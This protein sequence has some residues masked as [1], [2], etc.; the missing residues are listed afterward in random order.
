MRKGFTLIELLVVIAIIA[1]LAAILFPVFARAREKARQ[2]SCQSN[3]KQMATAMLMYAQDYDETMARR[4]MSPNLYSQVTDDFNLNYL[5]PPTYGYWFQSWAS[6]IYPYTKNAQIYID[7]S[8]T[9][10]SQGVAYGMPV[11]GLTPTG[12]ITTFDGTVTLGSLTRP[13]ETFMIGCKMGGGGAQYLLST[14]YYALSNRHNEGA[15]LS[16]CDGHV[17]WLKMI[18]GPIGNGWP[19]APNGWPNLTSYSYHPPIYTFWDIFGKST[20]PV[21]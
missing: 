19:E 7:P 13:A 6:L 18:A 2:A 8:T 5:P 11:A 4:S 12:R 3:H 1:I 15:N 17:K 14:Q 16:F 21:A 10:N 9:F 20:A